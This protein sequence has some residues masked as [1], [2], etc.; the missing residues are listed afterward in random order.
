MWVWV[1]FVSR[2]L[3]FCL[4]SFIFPVRTVFYCVLGPWM[5]V[6]MDSGFNVCSESLVF[7]FIFCFIM[8]SSSHCFPICS[9][10]RL[11]FYLCLCP[12][13][14]PCLWLFLYS[15]LIMIFLGSYYNL[16]DG[17]F[18]VLHWALLPSI[19][20]WFQIVCACLV[21]WPVLYTVKNGSEFDIKTM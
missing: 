8:C 15:C 11:V 5:P 6:E 18:G 20:P 21:S 4:L 1:W 19:F 17:F 13:V 3:E 12:M 14:F 9:F 16:S 10:L 2:V 7:S